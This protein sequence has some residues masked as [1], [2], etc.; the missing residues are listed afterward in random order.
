M[1]TKYGEYSFIVSPAGIPRI[2]GAY[3]VCVKWMLNLRKELDYATSIEEIS[4]HAKWFEIYASLYNSGRKATAVCMMPV[5]C[6]IFILR[7]SFIIICTL[8]IIFIEVISISYILPT[9]DDRR[10]CM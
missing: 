10:T 2:T 5:V 4:A 1:Y 6:N 7:L 3:A 9:P 8:Y